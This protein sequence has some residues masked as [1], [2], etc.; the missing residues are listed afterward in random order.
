LK[1]AIDLLSPGGRALAIS[2]HSLEDRI[3]KNIFRK[4]ARG[5]SCD[6]DICR[7]EREPVVTIL[8]KKPIVPGQDEVQR[9][10]RARSAKLRVCEKMVIPGGKTI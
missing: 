8:T 2:F 6:E 1:D 5:C 4:M 7:C 10:K 3:V 9:N